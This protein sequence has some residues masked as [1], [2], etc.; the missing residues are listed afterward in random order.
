MTYHPD[1]VFAHGDSQY[2]KKFQEYPYGFGQLNVRGDLSETMSFVATAA[3]DNV[4]SNSI[5]FTFLNRTDNFQF[6]FGPF[7]AM[8]DRLE[9]PNFGIIGSIEITFPGFMF[10]S[11]GGSSTLGSSF[12]F[13]STSYRESA[14]FKVGFWLPNI[15]LSASASTKSL[16]YQPNVNGI[17]GYLTICDTLTRFQASAEIFIKNIPVILR[18]N[19]GYEIYTRAYKTSSN[20]VTTDELNAWYAG[21]DLSIQ[22]SK[23]L[24]ITFGLET[25]I[26]YSAVGPMIA[27]DFLWNILK[28]NAGVVYTFF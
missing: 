13:T 2:H 14:E 21:L 25:P 4:L 10:L 16:S 11:L 27:P 24:K 23:P 1:R 5:S 20:H 17:V 28:A 22:V 12:D 3:R 18:L 7:I 6:E 19:G 15:I 26:V 9:T 8:G